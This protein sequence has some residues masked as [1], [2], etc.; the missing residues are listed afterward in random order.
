MK[1]T[2]LSNIVFEDEKE[3]EEEESQ[4]ILWWVQTLT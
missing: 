2:Q 1:L 4:T 3:E